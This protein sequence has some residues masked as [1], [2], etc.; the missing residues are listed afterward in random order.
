MILLS[1]M[2]EVPIPSN[3]LQKTV[4]QLEVIEK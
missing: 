3:F 1:M 4:K 2:D